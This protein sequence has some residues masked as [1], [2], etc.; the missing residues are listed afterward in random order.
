[1]E[2]TEAT[3]PPRRRRWLRFSLRAMLL[4]IAVFAIWLGFKTKNAR[5]QR[6]AL[7]AIRQAGGT[8]YFDYQLVKNKTDW[9]LTAKAPGPDWLR[10]L[11]GE[12]YF[13]E[14]VGVGFEKRSLPPEEFVKLLQQ[15]SRVH[16][17][18]MIAAEDRQR[19]TKSPSRINELRENQKANPSA[20]RPGPLKP[21]SSAFDHIP[22]T[23]I[24]DAFLEPIGKL[25]SLESLYLSNDAISDEGLK[26]LH[27][28]H[29][30]ESL[31]LS[32]TDISGSGLQYLP[33]KLTVLDLRDTGID[34]AAL[35]HVGKL[36][37]LE[38]LDLSGTAITDA[39]LKYLSGLKK[40]KDL[41]L[42]ETCVTAASLQFD[43]AI[44]LTTLNLRGTLTNDDG[45]LQVSKLSSL[46]TL[47]VDR[48]EIRDAGLVH[49]QHLKKLSVL[50]AENHA[51]SDAGLEILKPLKQLKELIVGS[52]TITYDAVF[53]L[54]E[55]LPA[56]K[57]SAAPLLKPLPESLLAQQREWADIRNLPEPVREQRMAELHSRNDDFG[58][59]RFMPRELVKEAA[60]SPD[61]D[62]AKWK[63]QLQPA[64]RK[65]SLLGRPS[66]FPTDPSFFPWRD[67]L[68]DRSSPRGDVRGFEWMKLSAPALQL[69]GNRGTVAYTLAT[70]D[71]DTKGDILFVGLGPR[72]RKPVVLHGHTQ[73]PW[74]IILPP[75]PFPRQLVSCSDDGTMRL[76]NLDDHSRIQMPGPNGTPGWNVRVQLGEE[77]A[78]FPV[79]HRNSDGQPA[80]GEF[81]AFSP[82]GKWLATACDRTVTFRSPQSGREELS[83][84]L[85]A[86]VMALRFDPNGNYL[87]AFVSATTVSDELAAKFYQYD[88]DERRAAEFRGVHGVVDGR[89]LVDEK[90]IV[91]W[92]G[93]GELVFWDLPTRAEIAALRVAPNHVYDVAFSPKGD[94]VATAGDDDEVKFWNLAKRQ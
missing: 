27:N 94:V 50:N 41:D 86:D 34:D 74:R 23:T 5:D 83:W 37:N 13:A 85:P 45:L 26:H 91:T 25:E 69:V 79:S 52:G 77:V 1:M 39:G 82:H 67:Y 15:L 61:P 3:K 71:P 62:G 54:Q 36:A 11:L 60:A 49:L 73:A 28:L 24:L 19:N 22:N 20:N 46:E 10:N 16:S 80:H 7:T 81:A 70:E 18:T 47:L 30:L 93:S 84:D 55:A 66:R 89:A 76:W 78:Q 58:T 8:P 92:D 48:T 33:I 68:V 6:A 64:S 44:P 88:L 90:T 31:D 63:I 2:A 51:I 56:T 9:D 43:S 35:E 57:I 40:L 4:I 14:V 87:F 59:T 72:L 21:L 17:I 75:T 65:E 38:R 32:D 29:R 42:S 12:E 53:R